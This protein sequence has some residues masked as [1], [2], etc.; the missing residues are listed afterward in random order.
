MK[1]HFRRILA[2]VAIIILLT[3]NCGPFALFAY[4]QSNALAWSEPVWGDPTWKEPVW[5]NPSTWES[6][7]EWKDSPEWK[8]SPDWKGSPEWQQPGWDNTQNG[9]NNSG[10]ESSNDPGQKGTNDQGDSKTN[11]KAGEESGKDNKNNDNKSSNKNNNNTNDSPSYGYDPN[12]E[13]V[14]IYDGIK[15]VVND[16]IGQQINLATEMLDPSM[17]GPDGNPQF[18]KAN[19]WKG[20]LV[21]G[22]K[23]VGQGTGNDFMQLSGDAMDGVLKGKDA[24]EGINNIRSGIQSYRSI[25]GSQAQ[26]GLMGKLRQSFTMTGPMS[27]LSKFNIATAAVGAGFSAYETGVNYKAWSNEKNFEKK[28]ELAGKTISSFGETLMNL[29]AISASVP[30]P[31]TQALGGALLITGGVLWAAGTGLQWIN[32]T[33]VGRKII[34]GTVDTVKNIGSNIKKGI[35]SLFGF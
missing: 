30:T 26:I 21:S 28:T 2:F 15:F 3:I 11:D 17:I 31:A 20:F 4:A 6:V 12:N 29:G 24:V 9:S 7:P 14:G 23:M 18:G 16:G 8:N 35:K 22:Y 19:S 5:E 10:G 1:K 32:K 25:A 13:G 34:K 27:T 33:K